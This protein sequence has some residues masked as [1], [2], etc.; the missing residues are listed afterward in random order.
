MFLQG[1]QVY[2][3]HS[4]QPVITVLGDMYETPSSGLW[5]H[6]MYLQYTYTRRENSHT[7]KIRINKMESSRPLE[8]TGWERLATTTRSGTGHRVN[9]NPSSQHKEAVP[10]PKTSR[11]SGI[12]TR[13]T[14]LDCLPHSLSDTSF[15][16]TWVWPTE[17]IRAEQK[18][19]CPWR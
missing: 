8:A 13:Q 5:R 1:N 6:H 7:H 16:K 9:S 11:E 15:P 14:Q 17:G 3:L 12:Q 18:E 19:V 2:S 10:S 4:H